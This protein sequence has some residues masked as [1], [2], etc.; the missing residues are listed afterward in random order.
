MSFTSWWGKGEGRER[1]EGG[2]WN[3]KGE[4]EQG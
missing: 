3:R 2:T 4:D 1:D